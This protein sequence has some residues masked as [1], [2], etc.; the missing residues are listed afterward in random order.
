MTDRTDTATADAR[1]G[2]PRT[3]KGRRPHYFADPATDRL[4]A[5]VVT[6]MEELSA[7]RDRV[8]SLER[9]LERER[10]LAEGAVEAFR[11]EGETAEVREAR[12]AAFTARVLR[13]LDAEIAES[14]QESPSFTHVK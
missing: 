3:A 8:D 9:V 1:T 2:L 10:V 11:P 13:V 4:L 12:R 7:T 5:M 6:L 14:P